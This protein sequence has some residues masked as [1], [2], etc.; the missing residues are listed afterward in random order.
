MAFDPRDKVTM[1][2]QHSPWTEFFQSLPGMLSSFVTAERQMEYQS[3]ERELDRQHS[4]EMAELNRAAEDYRY[5]REKKDEW[6]KNLIEKGFK[7][8]ETS[9]TGGAELFQQTTQ[10]YQDQAVELESQMD[11]IMDS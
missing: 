9:T 6:E 5:L 1:T 7:T 11:S 10:G 3:A 2:I 4:R 8:P